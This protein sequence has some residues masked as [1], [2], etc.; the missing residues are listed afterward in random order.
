LS[1]TL[2]ADDSQGYYLQKVEEILP[3]IRYCNY[4][5]GDES[6]KKDLLAMKMKTETG[7]ELAGKIDVTNSTQCEPSFFKSSHLIFSII[8]G[9]DIS[10]QREAYCHIFG[11]DLAQ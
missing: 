6:A 8:K 5:L 1:A 3:N 2:A 11:I 9:A 10:N 4:N 7:S